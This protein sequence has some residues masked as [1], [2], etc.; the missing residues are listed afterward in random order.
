VEF[1][2]LWLAALFIT[3]YPLWE[4]RNSFIRLWKLCTGPVKLGALDIV[5]REHHGKVDNKDIKLDENTSI[6]EQYKT[7]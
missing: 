2:W 6:E 1:I 5:S 7:V 3:F 4:L